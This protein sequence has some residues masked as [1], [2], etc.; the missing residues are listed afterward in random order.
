MLRLANKETDQRWKQF[1][2][3]Q[4]AAR[5]LLKPEQLEALQVQSISRCL[6]F[7]LSNEKTEKRAPGCVGYVGDDTAQFGII[8]NH[9][10][11]PYDY[12]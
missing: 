2:R 9:N 11:D 8:I 1:A 4:L 5:V 12:G 3:L 7:K 6:P 10:K